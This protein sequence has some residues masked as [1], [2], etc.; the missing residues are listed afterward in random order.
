M[1]KATLMYTG[2]V[3]WKPPA[4]YKSSC[5]IN[6]EWFPF[7][8]QTCDMK[9]GSW[10]YDGYQV[11]VECIIRFRSMFRRHTEKLIPYFPPFDFSAPS[12]WFGQTEQRY[13]SGYNGQRPSTLFALYLPA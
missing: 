11:R 9:F 10:T 6:V 7:D 1:T 4:I 2:E 8:E 3:Y 5:K 13:R 12:D